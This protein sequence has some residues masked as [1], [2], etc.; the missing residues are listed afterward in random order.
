MLPLVDQE[1]NVLPKRG[2]QQDGTGSQLY[3]LVG[4]KNKVSFEWKSETKSPKGVHDW[5]VELIPSRE[6]YSADDNPSVEL[7][8]VRIA[9]RSRK[10]GIPLDLDLP[11]EAAVA[12]QAESSPE[13]NSATFSPTKKGSRSRA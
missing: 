3:A 7:P 2:F 6:H 9:A 10:A 1:G 11:D 13:M 5:W 4:P 8:H 12:V